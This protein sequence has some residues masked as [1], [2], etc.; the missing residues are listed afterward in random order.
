MCSF[1]PT[2]HLPGVWMPPA[3]TAGLAGQ[4]SLLKWSGGK[5]RSASQHPALPPHRHLHADKEHCCSCLHDFASSCSHDGHSEL[6]APRS[7]SR[8]GHQKGCCTLCKETCSSWHSTLQLP[9]LQL[10]LLGMLH[11]VVLSQPIDQEH[12]HPGPFSPAPWRLSHSWSDQLLTL[13][14]SPP[15][16]LNTRTRRA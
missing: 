3:G 12:Q 13:S 7:C 8:G 11:A 15:H 4:P 6:H 1:C 2:L 16:L 10:G 9:W 14:M 5:H